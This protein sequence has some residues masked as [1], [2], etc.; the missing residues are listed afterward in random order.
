MISNIIYFQTDLFVRKK[1]FNI[2]QTYDTGKNEKKKKKKKLQH[3]Y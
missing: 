2:Y 1:E 3:R